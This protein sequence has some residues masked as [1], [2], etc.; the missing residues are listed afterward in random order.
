MTPAATSTSARSR[1]SCGSTCSRARREA[2]AIVAVSPSVEERCFCSASSYRLGLAA[3]S[4]TLRAPAVVAPRTS[5]RRSL[6]WC[7]TALVGTPS[8]S[9]TTSYSAPPRLVEPWVCET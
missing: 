2:P 4:S 5:E 8:A 1:A 7:R 3:G 9:A 6:P